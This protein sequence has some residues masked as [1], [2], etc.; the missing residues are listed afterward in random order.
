MHAIIRHEHVVSLSVLCWL[1]HR[2]QSPGSSSSTVQNRMGPSLTRSV[3]GGG[4][5]AEMVVAETCVFGRVYSPHTP[6]TIAPLMFDVA[7]LRLSFCIESTVDI[8]GP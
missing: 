1:K 2:V 4:R 3:V 6:C 8:E 5:K 7:I